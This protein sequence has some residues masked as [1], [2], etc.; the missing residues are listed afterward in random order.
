MDAKADIVFYEMAELFDAE[1]LGGR[2]FRGSHVVRDPRDLVVS[3]YEYHKMTSEPWALRPDP[4]YGGR[5]YQEHLTAMDEHDGLMAEI[6]WMAASSGRAMRE[7]DYDRPGFIELRYEDA[8]ADECGTFERLFRWY[9]LNDTAT[10]LGMEAVE[11]LSLK[12]GGAG[13]KHVRS[14]Q[15]GEWRSRFSAD[16]VANFKEMTGDLVVLLG[17]E[18]GPD[19]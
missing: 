7:W 11:R 5:S 6:A 15:P 13:H 18:P 16:H 10:A 1:Q 12:G 2:P 19:W 9:G 3:G 8:F 14:G 17:Y 4:R